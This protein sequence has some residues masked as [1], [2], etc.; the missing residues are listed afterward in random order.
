MFNLANLKFRT[1][2]GLLVGVFVIGFAGFGIFSFTTMSEISVNGPV[3]QSIVQDK[4]LLADILPP[5]KY[6][7]DPYLVA[8]QMQDANRGELEKLINRFNAMKTE[9]Y[10]RQRVWQEELADG[11][12][13]DLMVRTSYQPAD[14]FLRIMENE[15]IPAVRAGDLEKA[16]EMTAGILLTTF[17]EHRR[18]IDELVALSIQAA[19]DKE[20]AAAETISGANS[21]MMGIAVVVLVAL[22][23]VALF[24]ARSITQPVQEAVSLLS[25]VAGGDLTV[26][27]SE[28]SLNR[29]DEIGDLT[30]A[31]S[32]MK[33]SLTQM[34]GSV[35]NTSGNLASS[36]EELATIGQQMSSNADETSSQAG[37]VSAASE[38]VSKNLQTVSTSAEEMMSSIKEIAKNSNEAASVADKAVKV[39]ETTN[40]TISKLGDSSVEIGQVIK[41]I[42]S[43]AQQTNLLAL[44]ATIEAARAG[45]AGKGFAVVA[46]E[47]KELAKE[48]AKATE[49]ISQKI[50]AIQG[51]SKE[52]VDAIA[53]ISDIIKQINDIANTIA[54]SVEEQTATSTE[55]TRTVGEAASGSEEISANMSSVAKA[56]QDTSAGANSTQQATSELSRMAGALQQVVGQF[57]LDRNAVARQSAAAAGQFGAGHQDQAGEALP[58]PN[59][60]ARLAAGRQH[61]HAEETVTTLSE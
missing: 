11:K 21:L 61:Q 43:I 4:D 16:E 45:E 5:P 33:D 23:V 41:V 42:T 19:K 39:A 17:D 6:V 50:E 36:S 27:P 59:H 44:N 25:T 24:V 15:Y 26:S 30:R 20:R 38:Q 56:A 54:A 52:S 2:L 18:A 7:V 13:K 29:K 37:V 49:E 55:M 31:L 60:E 32:R 9:Y 48:T 28:Q 35:A 58:D 47:V 57:Q 53:Q 46:N 3:Y 10:E 34:I 40:Q 14:K 22:F 51:D 1:K 12:M 8:F